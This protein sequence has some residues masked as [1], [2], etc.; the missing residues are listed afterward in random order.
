VAR[1]VDPWISACPPERHD[2]AAR[3]ADVAEQELDDGGGADVLDADRVLRPAERI[4]ER[5]GALAA[6]VRAQGLGHRDDVLGAAA[7]DLGHELRRI[8]P[9]VLLQEL[10]DAA[11]MLE[12]RVLLGRLA[13]PELGA[14]ASLLGGVPDGGALLA[15]TCRSKDLHPLVLPARVVVAARD[16]VP[17]REESVQVLSVLECLV[18]D[19]GRVRVVDHVFPKLEAVLED[20]VHDPA[21]EGDVGARSDLHPFR[22]RRARTREAGI[23]VGLPVRPAPWPPSPTGSR[24]GGSRP[25]SSP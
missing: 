5:R 3:P 20:V 6:G 13:V 22:R 25:C 4:D 9:E 14:A 23:D 15:V 11:W 1:S 10:V 18:D 16:R 7:A 12:R 19:H 21:E 2:P 24:P 17:P 8:A